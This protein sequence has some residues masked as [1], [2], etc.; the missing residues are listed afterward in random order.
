MVEIAGGKKMSTRKVVRILVD[1]GWYYARDGKGSHRVYLNDAYPEREVIVSWHS[2]SHDIPLGTLKSLEKVTGLSLRRQA[3]EI[4]ISVI[5]MLGETGVF[6]LASY[7]NNSSFW[8]STPRAFF[9]HRLSDNP[10]FIDLYFFQKTK[11]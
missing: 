1:N 8:E 4:I 9:N 7:L 6:G 11:V 2:S 10:P 5:K 3:V